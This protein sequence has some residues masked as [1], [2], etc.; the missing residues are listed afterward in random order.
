MIC[1]CVHVHDVS[2][3]TLNKVQFFF[4]ILCCK[5]SRLEDPLLSMVYKTRLLTGRKW[6]PTGK[7]FNPILFL[8]KE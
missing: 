7:L 1:L 6:F 8:H 4:Y 5:Q 2:N 3:C